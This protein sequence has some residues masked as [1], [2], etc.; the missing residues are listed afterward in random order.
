MRKI[1]IAHPLRGERLD[2]AVI[3]RNVAHVTEICRRA[4][5]EHPLVL[6]EPRP[7]ARMSGMVSGLMNFTLRCWVKTPDFW[8]VT[9]DL[10]EGLKHDFDQAKIHLPPPQSKVQIIDGRQG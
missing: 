7:E 2:I 3:E 1:Y 5:E 6:D 10:N 8:A 9:Y 4:A